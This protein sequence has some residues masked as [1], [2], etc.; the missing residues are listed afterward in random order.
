MYGLFLFFLYVLLAH[1]SDVPFFLGL[2]VKITFT[3][4]TQVPW[5][6]HIN[7][8]SPIAINLSPRDN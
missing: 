2:G 8:Q 4:A 3:I 7:Q 1:Q 6:H 5:T